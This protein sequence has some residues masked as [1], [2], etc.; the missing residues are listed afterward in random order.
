MA[1]ELVTDL[2]K[3]LVSTVAREAKQE[4]RLVV[5]VDKEAKKLEDNL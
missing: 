2:I 5:G 1:E 3:L 4:I